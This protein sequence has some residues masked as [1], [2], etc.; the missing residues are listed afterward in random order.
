MASASTKSFL[1]RLHK[2]LHELPWDQPNIVP[3][4]TQSTAEEVSSGAGFQPDQRGLQVGRV[5]QQLLLREL[6][7]HQH[8][9]GCSKRHKVKGGLAQVDANRMNLHSHDLLS[10]LAPSDPRLGNEEASGG[11]SH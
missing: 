8:L 3:L 6:L 9:T 10:E 5:G 2:G 11:P 1:V 4:L 7:I